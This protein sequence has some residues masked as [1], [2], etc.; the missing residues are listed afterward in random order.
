MIRQPVKFTVRHI[1]RST[2]QEPVMPGDLAP[3]A[4]AD[5]KAGQIVTLDGGFTCAAP[6]P[7]TLKQ[8][9]GGLYFD[10]AHGQHYIDSQEDSAGILIG[11]RASVP[12]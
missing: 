3:L 7:V 5:A 12:E 2:L 1:G 4:I 6:G 11:I 8:D 9:E 10:C